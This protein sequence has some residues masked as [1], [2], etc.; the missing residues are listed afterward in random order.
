M[1][2]TVTYGIATTTATPGAGD[3]VPDC[4]SGL[5]L[6]GAVTNIFAKYLVN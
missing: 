2:R 3:P 6:H 4:R 5:A 1:E